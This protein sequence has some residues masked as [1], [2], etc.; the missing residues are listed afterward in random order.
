[1]SYRCWTVNGFGVCIDDIKTTPARVL[2]LA[3]LKNMDEVTEYLDDGRPGWT[4]SDLSMD[5]FND[6]C[7]DYGEYGVAYVLLNAIDEIDISYAN[8]YCGVQYVLFEPTY[9]WYMSQKTAKIT[10]EDVINVMRKYISIL[11]DDEV[12]IDYYSVENGG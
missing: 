10:E 11:T 5:D 1:M 6:L 2:E 3:R 8:D 7:G 9:P 4:E 12:A